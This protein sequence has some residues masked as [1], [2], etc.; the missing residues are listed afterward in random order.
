MRQADHR[1]LD[2]DIK[3]KPPKV[4]KE[5]LQRIC[6][7][8]KPYYLQL[9]FV[10]IAILLAAL[11][12][13]F[14]SILT[15]RIIDEGF[16]GGNFKMLLTLIA[17]AFGVLILIGLVGLV[18]SYLGAWLSQ[19]IAKD[20]RNQMYAHLQKLSQR[21]YNA[22]KQGEIITRMTSDIS[23][24]ETVITGTLSETVSNI[25][26]LAT[27]MAA[28]LQKNWILAIV[29]IMVVP[30]LVIPI[31]LVGK[32]RWL[33]TNESQNLNDN[34]NEILNETLSV[35][36]QQLV[37][38]FTKEDAEYARYSG[39]NE[40]LSKLRVLENTL[41]RW[42][43]MAA[44]TFIEAGPM[45]IY[46]VGGI[47]ILVLGHRE[48]TVGDI[49]VL[50]ALMARMYKPLIQIMDIQVEFIRSLAL[51][52]RIFDYLDLPVEIK[53]K[54]DAITPVDCK[55]N[56]CFERVSFCYNEDCP[57]IQDISFQVSAGKTLAIVGPSGA[58]KSTLFNLIP[59]LYDVV[60]GEIKIDGYDIKDLDFQFLRRNVGMVTQ[61]S[62]LFNASI[63]DNLLYANSTATDDEI[64]QAC[65]EAHIHEYIAGLPKGYD[66]VAGNRGVKLSGGEKQRISIARAILKDP[67]ILILDEATSSLD[68]ISESLI[69]DALE[70]LMKNRTSLVIAHRLSTIMAADE[71]LVLDQGRVAERGTHL[72][73]LENDG[74]YR[75]MY[76]TQ[77]KP[78]IENNVE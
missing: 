75:L 37:K 20:M 41:G 28:M 53:S 5:L 27:S 66:T 13:V 45:F 16:I 44:Q 7:Y 51:F 65:K 8:F 49:T 31:K 43:R 25:A 40:K 15:G 19:N 11:L 56:L 50:V 64:I 33:L 1:E 68:S 74:I 22:G 23:G 58:G 55:G 47:L 76:E 35:S 42:F 70:P 4:T 67:K 59:R 60:S 34:A 9:F 62:Y 18:Q 24:V 17:A 14:P 77:F 61:E 54:P 71:I 12:G 3:T 39:V 46:L 30:V 10:A 69:Q 38:L 48:L 57:I 73:L 72:K 52:T 21:F 2:K 32:K 6:S 63:K 29:G 78:Y 36:G 26:I